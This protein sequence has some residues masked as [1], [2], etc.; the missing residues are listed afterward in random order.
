MSLFPARTRRADRAPS[1]RKTRRS[2]SR[3]GFEPLEP[4]T[5]LSF[6]PTP[7]TVLPP[8]A[9]PIA[10]LVQEVTV[11]GSDASPPGYVDY[12]TD[13]PV[14]QGV[15]RGYYPNKQSQ[16]DLLSARSTIEDDLSKALHVGTE[17][18]GYVTTQQ[19][20]SGGYKGVNIIGVLPG[21]GLDKN[22]LVLIGAHYDSAQNPGADDDASG[23]AGMLEAAEVLGDHPFDR[24]L[25]FVA[26]DQEEARSNG[27][28]Q[29]SK[30]YADEARAAGVSIVGALMLDMI[31][32]NPS[33]GNIVTVGL[34]RLLFNGPSAVLAHQ[35]AD[36]YS[37]YT[38]LHV[39]YR[40][41]L[42]GTDAYSFS[43]DGYASVSALEA[44]NLFGPSNPYYH[45]PND[46]YLS[47]TDQ[48]QTVNRQPYLDFTYATEM[49][50]GAVAFAAIEARMGETTM[51]TRP[52]STLLSSGQMPG[53]E[54][55]TVITL[56][57]PIDPPFALKAK[58]NRDTRFIP[59]TV[60]A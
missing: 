1:G 48:P 26:F 30:A 31:A 37:D 45:T 52:T 38:S 23:V 60:L 32:Y 12:F 36:T 22:Q 5:L 19:F 39:Q 54:T 24:T 35:V 59:L 17:G 57:M 33:G 7:S 58:A 8:P 47:S 15:Q 40:I 10:G 25:V 34:P 6:G 21:H 13:L 9:D 41:T 2:A 53:G 44:L 27:S 20:F 28:L 55:E 50:K 56:V 3:R 16:P 4:R 11:G 46:Y 51:I 18:G 49:T 29:G 42:N 14:N 43:R